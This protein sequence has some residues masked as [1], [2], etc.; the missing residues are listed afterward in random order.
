[1]SEEYDVEDIIDVRFNPNPLRAEFHVKWKNC[2]GQ[3][4]WEPLDNVYTCPLFL[5]DLEKKKRAALL[6]SFKKPPSQE[7]LAALGNFKVIPTEIQKKFTDPQEFIPQGN[8]KIE[9]IIAE[10]QS[11]QKNFLWLMTF[12]HDHLPCYVRK[13]V[14]CYYWPYEAALFMKLQV[15]RAEKLRRAKAKAEA[16]HP[17]V[18]KN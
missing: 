16:K 8:E 11:A 12:E 7:T 18:E 6:R 9:S 1:M 17:E 10:E 4:T 2:P 15:S 3:N 13:S 14:A 5:R